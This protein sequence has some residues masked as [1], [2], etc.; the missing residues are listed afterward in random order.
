[1]SHMATH[2][3]TIKIVLS[4]QHI[5]LS[6]LLSFL[7]PYK[8]LQS[9]MGLKYFEI[10]SPSHS[11]KI[12]AHYNEMPSSGFKAC[13]DIWYYTLH[14]ISPNDHDYRHR[15]TETHLRHDSVDRWTDRQI[16]DGCYQT[17][18]IPA[19][20]SIMRRNGPVAHFS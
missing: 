9:T 18:Y 4:F 17:Y 20:Q 11:H 19:M 13:L 10:S 14:S 6:F 5:F 12:H 7:F 8:I 3:H 15:Q 1:M 2:Y 16:A